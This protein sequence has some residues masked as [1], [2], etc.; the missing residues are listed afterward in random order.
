MSHIECPKCRT[1]NHTSGYGLAAP[2]V[3]MGFHTSCDDCGLL[4]ELG[5]ETE[6]LKSSE[7]RLVKSKAFAALAPYRKAAGVL[8][9]WRNSVRRLRPAWKQ[10]IG[11]ASRYRAWCLGHGIT[12]DALLTA[13]P[14]FDV[15][16]WKP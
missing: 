4:L 14:T 13:E 7:A 16:R 8:P 10:R 1:R 15:K 3:G 9:K 12:L 11:R 5:P 2:F 6:G